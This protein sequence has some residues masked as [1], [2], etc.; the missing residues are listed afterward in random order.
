MDTTKRV[1]FTLPDYVYRQLSLLTVPGQVSQ[2][3]TEAVRE[4]IADRQTS[5]DPVDE[6]LKLSG[7][8]PKMTIKQI[9]EAVNL[10]RK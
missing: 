9:K 4:K 10:G 2:F 5:P 7:V 6:F 3:V 1:T 8:F